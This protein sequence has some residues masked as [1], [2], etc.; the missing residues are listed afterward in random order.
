MAVITATDMT[1]TGDRAVT[2]T[3][4][5]ASDTLTFSASKEPVL[6]LNNVTGGPLTPNLLGDAAT[7]VTCSGVGSVDVSGGFTTASIAA[8]DSAAIPLV[9]IRSY[10]SGTTVTVTGG[11]GIEAQLLE[12]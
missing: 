3:T 2:V 11:D 8:G 1:G 5:G 10:L 6:V 12:F 4:L 9:S 7:T